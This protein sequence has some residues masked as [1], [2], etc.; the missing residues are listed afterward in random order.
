VRWLH[1]RAAYAYGGRRLVLGITI[2]ITER[3]LAEERAQEAHHALDVAATQADFGFGYREVRS[4]GGEWSPQLKVMFG[5]P[6]D[7]PTPTRAQMLALVDEADRR[8]VEHRLG[9]LPGTGEVLAFEYGVR[10][11]DG[12]R[13]VLMTRAVARSDSQG[14]PWRWYFVVIDVTERRQAEM[15]LRAKEL[16]ERANAAKTEFLSRMSHEL[17]TP[18]N[19]VLG[20]AQVMS[21]D[22]SD[23][24]SDAHRARVAHIQTAGW[25]LLALI[26]DVLDLSRIEARQTQLNPAAVPLADVVDECLAMNAAA[27]TARGVAMSAPRVVGMPATVWADRTRLKQVLL[28]LMSNGI[29]YNRVG[30]RLLLELRA[31][32]ADAVEIAVHDEGSGLTADQL[33]RLFEPFN[34]LGRE[35]GAIE[36]TGIGLALSRML[37]EQMGGR[38]QAESQPGVGSVFRLTLPAHDKSL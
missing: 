15:A 17:R 18:L 34:R 4:D 2:D 16:A 10:R 21:L 31:L 26:N 13:R 9:V 35:R 29:K 32:G 11:A 8:A 23:P 22:Q 37:A 38:L 25:H 30:G 1:T 3:K 20:F 7:A 28:N 24:L 19:A 5:L 14:R 36:G 12:S 33:A 27:A 6:P